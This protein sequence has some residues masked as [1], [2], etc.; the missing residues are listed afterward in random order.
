MCAV[1]CSVCSQK[2]IHVR[3][4]FSD[5]LKKLL[6]DIFVYLFKNQYLCDMSERRKSFACIRITPY[7]AEYAV[8][9]FHVDERTGAICIPDTSDL[10][11][12]VWNGMT[13][14]RRGDIPEEGNLQILLPKRREGKNPAYYNKMSS[15]SVK[16]FDHTLRIIFNFEYHH[17]LLYHDRRGSR[18][19]I[20][21]LVD[22]FI[23]RY[24]LVSISSDALIKNWQRY[25]Q[26]ISPHQK[27]K[28][29][30]KLRF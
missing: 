4:K 17:F 12:V 23:S 21:D 8:R 14:P 24:H 5:E 7:L 25:R 11:H 28:Y 15:Q 22:E 26:R 19:N 3:E 27:R 30:K 20:I 2:R 10:Y 29:T 1:V 18:K 9:K 13:K 6:N 16:A